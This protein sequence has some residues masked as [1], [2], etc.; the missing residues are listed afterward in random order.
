VH[1]VS[2]GNDN[3]GNSNSR[4]NKLTA[5][6]KNLQAQLEKALNKKKSLDQEL[7]TLTART[8]KLENELA[9]RKKNFSSKLGEFEAEKLTWENKYKQFN[10]EL[11]KKDNIIKMYGEKAFSGGKDAQLINT[12]ELV[13]SIPRAQALYGQGDVSGSNAGLR[14]VHELLQLQDS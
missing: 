10:N 7:L 12:S 2:V 4:V 1:R 13:G 14:G 8:K 11:R 6:C 9:E 3:K 5:D